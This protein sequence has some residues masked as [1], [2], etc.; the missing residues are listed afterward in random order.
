MAGC[1][2]SDV[3]THALARKIA[4]ETAIL[5]RMAEAEG[6]GVLAYLLALVEAE[7]TDV[8]RDILPVS[9]SHRHQS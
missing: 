3:D 4:H 2:G 8:Q 1:N 9:R 6:M 7:A 5:R